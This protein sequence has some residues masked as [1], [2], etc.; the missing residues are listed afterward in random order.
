MVCFHGTERAIEIFK[1][2][3]FQSQWTLVIN[4]IIFAL[5]SVK[6]K[7]RWTQN[8]KL[9]ILFIREILQHEVNLRIENNRQSAKELMKIKRKS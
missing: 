6:R 8:N 5:S 7:Y 3:H 1:E 9:F 4:P 2:I